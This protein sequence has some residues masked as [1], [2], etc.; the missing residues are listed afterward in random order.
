[1]GGPTDA[2]SSDEALGA[3]EPTLRLGPQQD[4]ST[5][6]GAADRRPVA[7]DMSGEG[8]LPA[9]IGRFAIEAKLGAGGS[10]VDFRVSVRDGKVAFTARKV[11]P[12][13]SSE[14]GGGAD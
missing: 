8:A 11:R 2:S 14:G 13:G 10:A 4:I 5:D 3:S 1:M 7:T 9:R 6:R 12:D